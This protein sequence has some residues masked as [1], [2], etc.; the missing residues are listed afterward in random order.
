MFLNRFHDIFHVCLNNGCIYLRF[1][2]SKLA[3]LKLCTD[4]PTCIHMDA[5]T[6]TLICT[7]TDYL[8]KT[9]VVLLIH[10][11]NLC[12]VMASNYLKLV[13]HIQPLFPP[14]RLFYP[15]CILCTFLYKKYLHTPVF[16]NDC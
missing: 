1:T 15:H 13:S 9:R 16:F 8:F 12:F 10:P 11:L 6:S 5:C 2:E 3:C 14:G 7:H 4:S